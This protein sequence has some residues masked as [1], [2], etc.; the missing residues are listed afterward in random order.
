MAAIKLKDL[1][2][3]Q[4]RLAQRENMPQEQSEDKLQKLVD[5]ISQKASPSVNLNSNQKIFEDFV[6]QTQKREELLKDATSEQIVIFKHLE[7]TIKKLKDA[8]HADS[9]ELRKAI[10]NLANKLKATPATAARSGMMRALTVPAA[11]TGKTPK[12]VTVPASRAIA[13]SSTK[14]ATIAST[15]SPTGYNL[16]DDAASVG[17]T[18]DSRAVMGEADP[19]DAADNGGILGNLLDAFLLKKGI[20]KLSPAGKTKGTAQTLSAAER[21]KR[22]TDVGGFKKDAQGRFRNAK[23]QYVKKPG[24]LARGLDKLS[25]PAKVLGKVAKKLPLIGGVLAGGLDAKEEYDKS[26][27]IAKAATVGTASAAGGMAGAMGGAATGAALGT[28]IFPGVGTVIG[29]AI[30]GIAGGLGGS[31]LGKTLGGGVYDAVT[32][33]SLTSKASEIRDITMKNQ[34]MA[35]AKTSAPIVVTAPAQQAMPSN[36]QTTYMPRGEVRPS[37][38]ALE[39]YINRSFSM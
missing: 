26:G 19:A 14:P 28:M 22:A 15:L 39:R 20:D 6:K 11:A 4:Q 33:P 34:D 3:G 37:E 12:A 13:A 1:L 17:D 38:N 23:G 36:N 32:T 7:D 27:D 31:A 5:A 8:G 9:M 35:E 18:D 24:L 25:G 10:E 30:G 16:Y 21:S 2:E 29:G